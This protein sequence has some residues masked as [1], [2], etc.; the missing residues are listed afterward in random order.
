[1]VLVVNFVRGWGREL[2]PLHVPLSRAYRRRD[3]L[4]GS[5]WQ[6]FGVLY[7]CEQLSCEDWLLARG[8][9]VTPDSGKQSR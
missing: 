1:M 8:G 6:A 5:C 3:Q 4:P 7:L 2:P 9:S